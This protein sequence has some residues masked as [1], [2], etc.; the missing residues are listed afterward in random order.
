MPLCM[1]LVQKRDAHDRERLKSF[2]P[3]KMNRMRGTPSR[4]T[5]EFRRASARQMNAVIYEH[6]L[7]LEPQMTGLP[8]KVIEQN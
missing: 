8:T 2:E 7:R 5:A 3:T 1:G 6:E 4:L